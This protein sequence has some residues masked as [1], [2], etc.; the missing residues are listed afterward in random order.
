M[1]GPV[2]YK[3]DASVSDLQAVQGAIPVGELAESQVS[4][5]RKRF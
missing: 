3:Y 2:C 1:K 5:V 4:S